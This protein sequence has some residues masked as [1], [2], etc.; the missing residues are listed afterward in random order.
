[1]ISHQ[2]I[3]LFLN[4]LFDEYRKRGVEYCLLR[5][6]QTLPERLESSDIDILISPLAKQ[7]NRTILALLTEKHGV[8]IYNHYIDER[9]DQ[10]FLFR[11]ISQQEIFT[12]QLDYFFDTQ[13]Y[14]IQLF[15]GEEILQTRIPY[16]NFFVADD[17]WMVLD[18]WLFAYLLNSPLPKR[19]HDKFIKVFIQQSEPLKH[20]LSRVFGEKKGYELFTKIS[21]EG[22]TDLPRVGKGELLAILLK[23]ALKSP[24]LH[25]WRFPLFLYYR[26]KYFLFPQGEFIS[27]SGPDG[28][29]KTTIL[30]LAKEQLEPIFRFSAKNQ[31]HTRPHF[32]PRIA[33]IAKATKIIPEVDENYSSP[34]RSKPSGLAG[35]LARFFYYLLD[36]V[37]GYL[38]KIRPALV[39]RELVVYDRYYFD[40]AADPQR[41]RIILPWWLR[42]FGLWLIPLPTTAFF[43]KVSSQEVRRRKQELPLE[44]IAE[45]NLAYA[46]LVG[47]WPRLLLIENEFTADVVVA[48][49]VD[50]VIDRKRNRLARLNTGANSS[51]NRYEYFTSLILKEIHENSVVIEIGAGNGLCRY[52]KDIS[53][54]A[55]KLIGID[56]SS[57]I[58]NNPY[59]HESIKAPFENANVP[60]DSV[61]TIYSI[62]V[63]EHIENPDKVFLKAHKIL[64][65]RGKFFFIT[66]NRS[67]YFVFFSSLA[68]KLNIKNL[69]IEKIM[70]A[71]VNLDYGFK[72]YYLINDEFTIQK[73]VEQHGFKEC[74]II[75]F[76]SPNAI[77]KYLPKWFKWMPFS[78]SSAMK[79]FKIPQRYYSDIIAVMSK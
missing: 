47:A 75:Y 68:D 35:S 49:L 51:M 13:L 4:D 53:D 34:H 31:G 69:W 61:D 7:K 42:K 33:T 8:V 9:F 28:C 37:L 40:I 76:D 5:N 52:V 43:I 55:G 54:K 78:I 38:I 63:M 60:D 30:D 73:L 10:F 70:K 79:F 64:K 46:K 57:N 62:Y 2:S 21:L 77:A 11:R 56:P 65:E 3:Q 18:K 6:Y 19:Y 74:K 39:R 22:F 27:V 14:G 23:A 71:K 48:H 72:S 29:G 12:L 59:V 50:I 32:F 58:E 36:Y 45:L 15:S 25:I 67:H 17:V 24:A 16:K 66:P 1:M 44:R 20:M 26:L 41:A